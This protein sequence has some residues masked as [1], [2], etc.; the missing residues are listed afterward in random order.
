MRWPGARGWSWRVWNLWP[1]RGVWA[2]LLSRGDCEEG[3][4]LNVTV[5][6]CKCERVRNLRA[7][8]GLDLRLRLFM[9]DEV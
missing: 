5:S 6:V 2:R 9:C 7:G 3:V 8:G 4:C 1:V